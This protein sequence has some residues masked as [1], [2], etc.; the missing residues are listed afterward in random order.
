MLCNYGIDLITFVAKHFLFF[1]VLVIAVY[2]EF[3][4]Y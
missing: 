1:L 3:I 2:T 4:C